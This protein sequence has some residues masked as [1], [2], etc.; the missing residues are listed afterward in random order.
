MS[1]LTH[2]FA[3]LE[4]AFNRAIISNDATRIAACISDDW[5][6]ITP[7]AGPVSRAAILAVIGTDVLSHDTMTKEILSVRQ[8]GDVVLV[9]GRGQN[10]GRFRG[11]PMEADEWITDVYHRT[12]GRW[13][14]VLTHLTPFPGDPVSGTLPA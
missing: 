9:V 2:A 6:L 12:A 3:A 14:C 4:D 10:T 7:E 8:Y 13:L 5:Q 1:D 11:A